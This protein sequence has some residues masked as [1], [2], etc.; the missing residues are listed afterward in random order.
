[1]AP[2]PTISSLAPSQE[3][4]SLRRAGPAQGA[5]AFVTG[6][7]L[8]SSFHLPSATHPAGPVVG[9]LPDF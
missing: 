1:M 7:T 5:E 8:P 4:V 6:Y 2:H 9:I 3:A